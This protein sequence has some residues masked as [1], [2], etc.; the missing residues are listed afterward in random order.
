VVFLNSLLSILDFIE[1]TALFDFTLTSVLIVKSEMLTFG[2]KCKYTSRIIPPKFCGNKN[3]CFNGIV[4]CAS[5]SY[6]SFTDTIFDLSDF[7]I[8][9]GSEIEKG[10]SPPA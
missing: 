4:F 6:E 8:S 10:N 2:V 9:R 1:I 3:L 7:K 5:S